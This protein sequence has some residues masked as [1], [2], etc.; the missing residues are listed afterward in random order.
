MGTWSTLSSTTVTRT[1]NCVAL[2]T[3]RH[4]AWAQ[5]PRMGL[6]P[7]Y[8]CCTELPLLQC[9][10]MQSC[11]VPSP[12]ASLGVQVAPQAWGGTSTFMPPWLWGFPLSRVEVLTLVSLQRDIQV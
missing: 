3:V 9:W 7:C 6:V 4:R 12:P 8:R 1:T 11:P 5:H 2:V 10:I